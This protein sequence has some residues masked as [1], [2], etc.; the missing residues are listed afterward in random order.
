MTIEELFGTLQQSII[1]AWRKHLRTSKYS[2]HMALDEFYTEMPE[3]VDALIE[4]W[5]GVNGRKPK[6]FDNLLSSKNL[7]TLDYLKSLRKVVKD[8]YELMNGEPELEACLDNIIELI[9]S[10]LYKIKELKENKIMIDLKDYINESL[11]SEALSIPKKF[12]VEFTY[13]DLSFEKEEVDFLKKYLKTDKIYQLPELDENDRKVTQFSKLYKLLTKS[14]E[15]EI[16][17]FN[18]ATYT[19]YEL[20]KGTV[21]VYSTDPEFACGAFYLSSNKVNE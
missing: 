16:F 6:S 2:K 19:A 7:G 12:N 10:T 4:A 17:N 9:D 14:K 5:M 21:V 3:K 11:I 20:P 8:G 13:D 1:G 18:N 15:L